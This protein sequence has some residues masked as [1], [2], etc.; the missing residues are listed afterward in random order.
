MLTRGT[1]EILQMADKGPTSFNEFT[2]IS[3]GGKRISSAT[4]S[5]RLAAL[6][7]AKVV[8]VMVAR[9]KSGRRILA[10]STTEKGK[11]VL[12]LAAELEKIMSVP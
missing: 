8:N 5:K 1:I 9:S 2:K 10:H 11:K 7:E 6:V 12:K 3:I 4:V